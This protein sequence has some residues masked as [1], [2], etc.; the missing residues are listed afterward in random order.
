MLGLATGAIFY[1]A[2][3]LCSYTDIVITIH[4]TTS[5]CSYSDRKYWNQ[6]EIMDVYS[7][8]IIVS[9]RN[10]TFG[11]V[12]KFFNFLAKPSNIINSPSFVANSDRLVRF[13]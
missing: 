5:S 10:V 12:R 4:T 9:D 8:N 7:N 2:F 6:T 13:I 3:A 1:A 11:V